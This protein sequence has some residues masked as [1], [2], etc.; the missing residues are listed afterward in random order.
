MIDL[1]SLYFFPFTFNPALCSPYLPVMAMSGLLSTEIKVIENILTILTMS[2]ITCRE[3]L[4]FNK[5][6]KIPIS[7]QK[8]LLQNFSY[9]LC[10]Y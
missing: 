3:I 1:K 8:M 9:F 6:L 5:A 7:V 4:S 2:L 10:S